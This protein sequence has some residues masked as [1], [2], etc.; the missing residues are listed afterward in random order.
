[1]M[2]D[3]TSR[4]LQVALAYYTAWTSHDLDTAM[5][6]IADDI[7][8]DAPRGRIEGAE[9]FRGFIGPFAQMLIGSRMIAAFGD[10][11]TA[12]IMYDTET[13]LVKS[14]PGAECLTVKDGKIVYSRFVFDR[15]PF[16]SA[17]QAA[18]GS[19]EA[20]GSLTVSPH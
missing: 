16:D 18:S 7:V 4:A 9:A 11:E 13:A 14:G 12:L 8:C 5:N 19:A 10:D 20:A 2:T 3:T 1:M 6:H 15:V 17:R